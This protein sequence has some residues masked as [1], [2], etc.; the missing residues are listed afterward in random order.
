MAINPTTLTR[1]AALSAI[2]GGALFIGVQIGHPHMDVESITTTEVIVRNTLK[3]VMV[4]LVLCGITGMFLS[5]VRR[6]GVLGLIGYVL[7]ALGYLLIMGTTFASAYVL[8]AIADTDP[9]FVADVIAAGTGGS[10]AGDLGW[11]A[12]AFQVQGAAYLG[13]G[14]LL[15]IALFRAGVLARWAAALLALSGVVSAALVVM[16]DAFYRLLAWPNG[17]A[18]IGLGYSLWATTRAVSTATSA[19]GAVGDAPVAIAGAE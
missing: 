4:A 7:F 8:P 11:L 13:G 1:G 9:A 10:P 15:G 12:V 2:A 3:L 14:L 5:Q 16:P 17:I 18:M 6:N 19:A